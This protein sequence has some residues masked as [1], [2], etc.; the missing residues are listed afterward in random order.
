[1]GAMTDVAATNDL[2]PLLKGVGLFSRCTDGE[3]RQIA[4]TATIQTVEAGQRVINIG[5]E[6]SDLFIVLEGSAD[7]VLNG[8]VQ[9]SFG[10]GDYFGELSAL[11]PAPRTS[12]VVATTDL[13]VA[14]FSRPSVYR[15]I[16][17]VPGVAA[18]M[19]EGLASSLRSQIQHV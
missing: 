3:C 11:S 13:R 14:V 15:L 7:A 6:G 17:T 4:R 1:M 12:D 10:A 9:R 16:D 5:D 18:K 2:I 19:L 8:E